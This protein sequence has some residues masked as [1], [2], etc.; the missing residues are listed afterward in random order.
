MI[1]IIRKTI[2]SLKRSY[3]SCLSCILVLSLGLLVFISVLSVLKQIRTGVDLYYAEAEFGDVFARVVSMPAN[4]LD[5]L[6][7]IEGVKAAEGVLSETVKADFQ[8][9]DQLVT[10]K[11]VGVNKDPFINKYQ[12][13]GGELNK[14][15]DVWLTEKFYESHH[16][17]MGDKLLLIVNGKIR[18]FNICGIVQSPEY[19]SVLPED[20]QVPDEY[21]YGVAFVQLEAMEYYLNK[22]GKVNEISLLLEDEYDYEALKYYIEDQLKT[23]GILS[24]TGRKNQASNFFVTDE[25]N[26]LLVLGTIVP[27]LFLSIAAIMVFIMLKRIIQQERTEIGTFKAFGYTS[28][29]ILT[30]YFILGAIISSISFAVGLVMG[31]P[32]G[33]FLHGYYQSLYKLPDAVFHFSKEIVIA[34]LIISVLVCFTAVVAGAGTVLK[35]LPAEAIRPQEPDIKSTGVE[36]N[37]RIFQLLFDMSGIMAL[38]S[39][40]RSKGRSLMVMFSVMISFT[41]INVLYALGQGAERTIIEQ[42][43]FVE[44]FDIKITMNQA[45]PE[46]QLLKHLV[47]IGGIKMAEG[48]L[49]MPVQ[50]TS[51]NLKVDM[52]I[53]GLKVDSVSL[54]I[55]GTDQKYYMPIKG[56]II[57]SEFNAEK[58]GVKINDK[59]ELH[60]PYLDTPVSVSVSQVIE[61][62]I[63]PGCYM[64]QD[65]LSEI[66]FNK[67][68][69]NM[70]LIH[71]D[72]IKIP[73]IQKELKGYPNVLGLSNQQRVKQVNLDTASTVVTLMNAFVF[74]SFLMG[75][76]AIYNVSRISLEEKKRELGTMRVLGYSVKEASAIHKLEQLI[77]LVFGMAAG[78]M[79]ALLLK[80]FIADAVSNESLVFTARLSAESTGV[81][82][83][84]CII[85]VLMANSSAEKIVKKYDLIDVLRERE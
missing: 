52:V 84:C 70:V 47:R 2:S 42:E 9:S 67:R 6:S 74:M 83:V 18:S 65:F 8:N 68:M 15:N 33:I 14:F 3:T 50:L 39:I 37:H 12:Y 75:F 76:G 44:K 19:I 51:K 21:T 80:D 62:A 53:Y 77:L 28:M 34:A 71:A 82:I 11:L 36:F 20:V 58:L 29:E 85:A 72:S 25:I 7:D 55:R 31:R 23:Y 48:V 46:G 35:I 1:I 69:A 78:I 81:A 26:S 27:I 17:E 43:K 22:V 60:S 66:F 63:G 32:F 73:E 61:E 4:E 13:T 5:Y 38:R 40:L 54:K 16:F 30:G 10:V 41:L 49:T 57:L 24:L 64:D 79:P 45:Y 56:G 59:I